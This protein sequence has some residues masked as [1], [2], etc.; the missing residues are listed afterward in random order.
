MNNRWTERLGGA[1]HLAL[2]CKLINWVRATEARHP[3]KDKK[4][5]KKLVQHGGCHG[6]SVAMR[7]CPAVSKLFIPIDGAELADKANSG[8]RTLQPWQRHRYHSAC[9]I[10]QSAGAIGPADYRR[11]PAWW[12]EHDWHRSGRQS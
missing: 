11:K 6:E 7:N 9:R 3:A 4:F 12:V 10:C 2:L 5:G 1:V 8:D